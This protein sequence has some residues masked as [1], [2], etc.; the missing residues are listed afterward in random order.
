MPRFAALDV[1]TNTVLMAVAERGP[2]GRLRAVLERE[3]ITRLGEGVDRTRRLSPQ[4]LERTVA[5][6]ARFAEEAR[7][8]EVRSFAACATSAARHATNGAEMVSHVR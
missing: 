6:I 8:Q 4:A 1:G 7:D 3:E 5:V 2:D